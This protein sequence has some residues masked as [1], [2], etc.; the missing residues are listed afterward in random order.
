MVA[1]NFKITTSAT[2]YIPYD[3]HE[4][5]LISRWLEVRDILDREDMAQL[6]LTWLPAKARLTPACTPKKRYQK[7]FTGMRF[8]IGGSKK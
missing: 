1:I 3:M 7:T 2:Q 6:R 4:I 5:S 8:R